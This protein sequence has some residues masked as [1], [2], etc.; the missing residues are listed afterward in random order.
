[1]AHETVPADIAAAIHQVVLT[2][3]AFGRAMEGPA[4]QACAK[5]SLACSDALKA[6]NAA[7]LHRLR[8]VE[9]MK[10]ALEAQTSGGA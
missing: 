7:I 10:A 3:Q 5:A 2:Q 8:G 4:N 1:M 6:L 9:E